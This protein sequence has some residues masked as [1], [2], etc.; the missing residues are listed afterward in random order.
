VKHFSES[1]NMVVE[2]LFAK[3]ELAVTQIKPKPEIEIQLSTPEKE[4]HNTL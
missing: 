4:G 3:S 1:V 2:M